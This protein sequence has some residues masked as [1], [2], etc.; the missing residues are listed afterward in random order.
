[1]RSDDEDA[2]CFYHPVYLTKILDII[3]ILIFSHCFHIR[4]V[5]VGV[6]VGVGIGLHRDEEPLIH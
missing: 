1:M 5:G 4:A 6:G 3:L 2:E